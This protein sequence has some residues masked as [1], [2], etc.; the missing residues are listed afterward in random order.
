MNQRY[1][2][3][4]SLLFL[5]SF[6]ASA[7]P[8][9]PIWDAGAGLATHHD[10]VAWPSEPANATDC[11]DN[12]GD[13]K[14]YTRFQNSVN[15]PRAQD[16]SN[17]GTTPQNYVNISSSCID[18][19]LPSIYY[20]LHQ[21][22]SAAEDVIMFRWRVEQIANTY[23]TGPNTGAFSSSS[24]WSSGLW[25]VLFDI[26]GSGYRNLA[27]HINGSSGGPSTAID[28]L[29]GIWG[30]T[31]QQSIDYIND[32]SVRL[33]DHNP[34][35]F[36]DPTSKKILN[37]QETVTPTDSWPNGSAET[38]WD[39]GTTRAK[40]VTTNSCNEYFVDYQIPVAMLDASAEVDASGKPGPKITRST[41]IS[42][43]FCTAN[44]LNNPFQKDC[45][46][47]KTWAADSYKPAPF[48]DYISFDKA[49]P[50]SQPIVASV[51]ALAPS[52]CGASYQLSATIQDVLGVVSGEVVS[53]VKAVDFYYWY[54]A[55]GDGTANEAGGEWMHA[56]NASGVADSLNTWSAPWDSTALPKGRYLIGVQA[57]DDNTIVDNGMTASGVDNRTFSYIAGNTQ[58]QVYINNAWITG[59]QA[60]FP[61]HNPALTAG[62]SE[63]WYGNPEVTGIQT[64]LVG[65]ALNVC[66]EAPQLSV[67]ADVSEIAPGG[68]VSFSMTVDNSGNPNNV[69]ID[70]LSNQ[71]PDG[72][73][74][75]A[76]SS[77]GDF[78]TEEPT[79]SGQTLTWAFGSPVTVSANASATLNFISLASTVAGN[80]NDSA[81]ATSSFGDLSSDP[82]AVAV[83]SARLA[84]NITPASYSTSPSGQVTYTLNHSNP[85]TVIVTGT[86]LVSPLPSGTTFTS[87]SD[88]CTAASN[89]SWAIGTLAPG[90]SGSVSVVLD[91][92][93]GFS[94][95]TLTT[96][97]TLSGLDP[98]STSVSSTAQSALY[99]SLPVSDIAAFT[100]EKT[101]G[102]V[103][104]APGGTLTYTLSYDNYG[105]ADASNVVISDTLPT[106]MAYVSSTASGTESAG[107]VTWNIGT[108]AASGT[109]SVTVTVTAATPFESPNP[110]VN[111]AEINW[112][113]GSAVNASVNVGITGSSC[114]AYY[115][116]DS[117]ASVGFDGTRNVATTLPV[118]L[119]ADT[120]ASVTVTAPTAGSAFLEAVRFYQDPATTVDTEFSGTVDTTL[121]IDRS[122]GPGLDIQ[123]TLYDYDSTSGT[124]VQL[125]QIISSFGGNT[126]GL[127]SFSVPVSGTLKK[128][129]RLLWVFEVRSQ[130]NNQSYDVQIQY[131][132]TVTNAISG[133][134]TFAESGAGFC[135]TPP[136]NLTIN[137]TVDLSTVPESSTTAVIYTI[138][139][140]NTGSSNAS[141]VD[142]D[143]SLPAGLSF[144]SAT[145]NGVSITP[146]GSAY[147][148]GTVTA[149]S[150]G[151]LI[152]N[153]SV[154]N[155]AT[156]LLTNT[157]SISS[158]QTSALSD[159]ADILVG[160]PNNGGGSTAPELYMSKKSDLS[161]LGAGDTVSYTLTVVNAGNGDATNVVV[162]DDFPG[163]SYF[164][165]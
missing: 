49:E 164:S 79:S 128:N 114:S 72:F 151:T 124:K 121:Y 35:A 52:S 98:T 26:D 105:G 91:V 59:E 56:A 110:A 77:T 83:G 9:P 140:A 159:T 115:F 138:D 40:L 118:P 88:S 24:P 112:D 117:T 89:V 7:D 42:M 65:V 156:G 32:A 146:T 125:G 93:A 81:S 38:T 16:D 75:Q 97:A 29:A 63:N 73:S 116:R 137:K 33:I 2:L 12:C 74:Y 96:S 141:N 123:S 85:S 69:T 51:T 136:A 67:S 150:S 6:I 126:K 31:P 15:D 165:Y 60:L 58:S 53:S 149:G 127:L 130:H 14:P 64:A 25:T 39:Y 109:G 10:P 50:Y 8:F 61:G 157:A 18:K 147:P 41:P 113:G 54:D 22:T 4:A 80:Y 82:I 163:Q 13:W 90:A 103:Q 101:A 21:G 3:R 57:V 152:I 30:Q 28:T 44:S 108:V 106:G 160:A 55:D 162:T 78:G 129:H 94:T 68:A 107:I 143:D 144:T 148:I 100:L 86:S 48:G 158:D 92:D 154:S 62:S 36:I 132:G 11:G 134:S 120:G 19:N 161:L 133:G 1:W 111:T 76:S 34:T 119:A 99:V 37:F 139:Y 122:N 87:C 153:A 23:A 145:L 43:M 27:A 17:G 104:V 66:G 135:V 5:V 20:Y 47:N 142:I 46:I 95:N 155:T 131:N 45:A 84:L 70:S 71:L 102:A